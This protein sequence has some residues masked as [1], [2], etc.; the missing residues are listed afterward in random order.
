MKFIFIHCNSN[1]NKNL[2]SRFLLWASNRLRWALN[3]GRKKGYSWDLENKKKIFGLEN[4]KTVAY[5]SFCYLFGAS[6][7]LL[8]RLSCLVCC[9]WSSRG[10][11][12]DYSVASWPNVRPRKSKKKKWAAGQISGRKLGTGFPRKGQK[13]AEFWNSFETRKNVIIIKGPILFPSAAEYFGQSRR[14]IVER[15]GDTVLE[16]SQDGNFQIMINQLT[17][18]TL[19]FLHSIPFQTIQ[20]SSCLSVQF[21]LLNLALSFLFFPYF[22]PISEFFLYFLIRREF[23]SSVQLNY[24]RNISYLMK[25]TFFQCTPWWKHMK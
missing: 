1:K 6:E 15:V 5:H 23:L 8:A 7:F 19:P 9:E 14:I 2:I 17:Q 20:L 10:C 16:E 21:V 11:T 4:R 24:N 18:P 3:R 22:L 13:G 12:L 25:E